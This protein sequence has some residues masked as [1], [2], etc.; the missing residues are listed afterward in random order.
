[1]IPGPSH[2]LVRREPPK[3]QSKGNPLSFRCTTTFVPEEPR[4]SDVLQ[5]MRDQDWQRVGL[6]LIKA[7]R[8]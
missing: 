6:M 4:G 7:G 2:L 5:E 1:V 8:S 3:V